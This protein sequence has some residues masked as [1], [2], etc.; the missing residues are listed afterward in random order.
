MRQSRGFTLVELLVVIA[1]IGILVAL[2]LPAVQSARESARRTACINNLRQ[3][4][5]ALHSYHDANG[6]FPPAGITEGPCCNTRSRTCWTIS[7]LP[8]IEEQALYDRYD[9]KAFNE[10][11]QNEFVRQAIVPTYGCPSDDTVHELDMPESGP[12]SNLLYRRGSY[13]C[14]AGKSDGTQWWDRDNEMPLSWRGP[15]HVAGVSDLG[16]ESFGKIIDGT[17]NTLAA[18]EMATATHQRRR[19][20][21]AYSY[22]GYNTSTSTPQSR[23]LLVDYD[24]C[25]EVGGTGGQNPCERGWGGFHPGVLLFTLC[26]GS[27]QQININID[28]T[29]FT[30]ISTIAGA[31]A[32]R[33]PQ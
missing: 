12:G 4:G 13:R 15:L 25:L 17:S 28:M 23:T 11:P 9:Q 27:T 1:I 16:A 8:Y 32:G 6:S 33:V 29:V 30:N 2:L 19:T 7:I 3:I 31:E 18:G 14:V 22:L 20:F 24:R 26:D 10:A 5:L 21:W